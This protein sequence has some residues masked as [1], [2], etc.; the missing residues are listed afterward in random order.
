MLILNHGLLKK[1]TRYRRPSFGQFYWQKPFS[2]SSLK[3]NYDHAPTCDIQL[4]LEYSTSHSGPTVEMSS[5]VGWL[6]S[7]GSNSFGDKLEPVEEVSGVP[8]KVSPLG[9]VGSPSFHVKPLCI[10]DLVRL[11]S[12][13]A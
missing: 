9:K 2:Y 6:R 11:V 7:A 1:R 10:G 12:A 8:P 13:V 5:R 4:A 3:Q